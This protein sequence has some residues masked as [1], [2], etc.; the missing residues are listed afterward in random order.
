[1]GLI[2]DR[3]LDYEA[4]EQRQVGQQFDP[5][6]DA[7]LRVQIAEQAAAMS[8]DSRYQELIASFQEL[9]DSS[10]DKLVSANAAGDATTATLLTGQILLL[11][12]LV[13]GPVRAQRALEEA[14]AELAR[15]EP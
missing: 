10:I 5:V 12:S 15:I 4:L 1:M 2:A 9:L 7:Q 8:R 3:R 6:R 13:E 14:K 11:R